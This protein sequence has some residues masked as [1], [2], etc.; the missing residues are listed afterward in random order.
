MTQK[1]A[2]MAGKDSHLMTEGTI[3]KE[4]LRFSAPLIAGNVLQ[5][6]YSTIDS[7]MVGQYVGPIALAAVGASTM[8]I[9]L[10]IA[11][12][13]GAAVGAGVIIAQYLGA[14]N[15]EKAETAV[16]TSLA[17]AVI[18]GI[19]LTAGGVL[20]IRSLLIWMDTP[21]DVLPDAAVYME[22]YSAGLLFNVLYNMAAGILNAAGNTKRPLLYLSMAGVVHVL[23]AYAAITV[24]HMGIAGAALATDIGQA[25]SAA[26][27]LGYLMRTRTD[28]QVFLRKI[29]LHRA[30]A[31]RILAVAVPVGVQNT[32]I[33]LSNVFVQASVNG[34]GAAVVAGFGVYLRIDGLIVLPILSIGMAATTFIG[35]NYG[36]GNMDRLWKGLA[37]TLA[38]GAVYSTLAGVILLFFSADIGRLFTGDETVIYECMRTM[39]YFCPYY[40]I[41]SFLN[42]LGGAVRGVGKSVPPMVVMLLS[43]CVFRIFWLTCLF[44]LQP[45]IETVY[46]VY[47]VSWTLGLLMMVWYTWQKGF[48]TLKAFSS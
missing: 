45:V 16:H 19:L 29:T 35:Q 9:Y 36:A 3:W 18:L 27:C 4:I 30:M 6:L 15:R 17:L 22:L 2:A 40:V 43:F 11:F 39:W 28:Y 42:I 8:V 1:G 14:R 41:M 38:M 48:R 34:F 12:S 37:V 20:F 13:Q 10:L 44:P 47:P 32:V 46:L 25:L 23:L 7:V 21:A 5:Q 26:L 24:F 31:R 33:N